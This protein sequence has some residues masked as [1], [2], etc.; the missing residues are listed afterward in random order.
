VIRE[1]KTAQTETLPCLHR[2][3]YDPGMKGAVRPY[4]G[5]RW[6]SPRGLVQ[7]PVDRRIVDVF[8][9]KQAGKR[10]VDACSLDQRFP[11]VPLELRPVRETFPAIS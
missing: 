7:E 1:R 8:T 9:L 10:I 5:R 11:L 3:H 6:R 4:G 2:D